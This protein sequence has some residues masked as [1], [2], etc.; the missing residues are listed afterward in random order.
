M[1]GVAAARGNYSRDIS[2][3]PENAQRFINENFRSGISLIK[4]DKE[5]GRIDEY[6]VILADGSEVSFSAAG[7]WTD[8]ETNLAGEV[9]SAVV[10]QNIRAYVAKNHDGAK[11]VG[12]E[13]TRSGYEVDMTGGVELRFDSNGNIVR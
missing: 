2:I 9:P 1:A 6:E 3:L 11:I 4:T 13:R 8:V 10:P 7:E 12:I 5:A